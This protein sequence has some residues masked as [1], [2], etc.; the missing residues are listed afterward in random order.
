MN[1]TLPI[2]LMTGT[3]SCITM[4]KA[5]VKFCMSFKSCFLYQND[6]ETCCIYISRLK[7]MKKCNVAVMLK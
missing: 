4:A 7:G 3:L 1:Y 6:R 2:R 5:L